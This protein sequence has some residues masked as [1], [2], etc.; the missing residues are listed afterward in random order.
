MHEC[1]QSQALVALE[2]ILPDG[3]LERLF[4]SVRFEVKG[5]QDVQ[6]SGGGGTVENRD[7][8]LLGCFG[9]FTEI[10][11]GDQLLLSIVGIVTVAGGILEHGG[12]LHRGRAVLLFLFKDDA[13][14]HGKHR[15]LGPHL[16]EGIDQAESLVIE[17]VPHHA[18][19]D[20]GEVGGV[21]R[22]DH[23]NGLVV[24]REAFL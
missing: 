15:G 12:K 21:L 5:R 8:F 16:P 19:D 4:E 2:R 14:L 13:A 3:V 9:R 6:Q 17:I 24:G 22:L 18:A 20:G 11:Q 1:Q 23:V 7:Q 10:E